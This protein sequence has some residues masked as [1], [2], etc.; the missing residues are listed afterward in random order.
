MMFGQEKYGRYNY[1][2]GLE[3]SRLV[4]A[5]S[6]HLKKWFDGEDIDPESNLNHIAHAMANCLMLL[7]LDR[8]GNLKDDRYKAND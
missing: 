2:K 8:L 3:A 6:R 7:D 1:R 5:A 4:A